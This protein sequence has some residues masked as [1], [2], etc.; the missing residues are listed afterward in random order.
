MLKELKNE[1]N[2]TFTE[3]GG[4]AHKT[5]YNSLLDMFAQGGAMRNRSDLDIIKLFNLAI[6]EDELLA[7]K[8][9]FYLRDITEGQGERKIFKIMIKHLA[10]KDS[11][12]L[13]R[14]IKHI[15]SYGR[16]DDMLVLIGTKYEGE[17]IRIIKEQLETDVKLETPSLLAKWLPSANASSK[18]TKRLAKKIIKLLNTNEKEYRKNLSLLRGKIKIVEAII[19]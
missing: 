2:K 4:V 6:A 10:D 8:M 1:L 5:T 11:G 3:N 14:N 7:L 12:L 18:E 9:A 16:W 13:K 15:P 17:V 19:S